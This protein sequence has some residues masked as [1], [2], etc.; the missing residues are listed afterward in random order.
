MKRKQIT[1]ASWAKDHLR[2]ADVDAMAKT[3][4]E[5]NE[6]MS[7]MAEIAGKNRRRKP[8]RNY[9]RERLERIVGKRK[10]KLVLRALLVP[11]RAMIN[12]G[13]DMEDGTTA[14]WQAMVKEAMR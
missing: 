1:L 9:M 3:I 12:A 11:T 2:L 14:V 13:W 6:I 10:A 8:T 5:T 4:M 7:D